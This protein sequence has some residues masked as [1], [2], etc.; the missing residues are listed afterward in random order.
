MRHDVTV[1]ATKIRKLFSSSAA[2]IKFQAVLLIFWL[3]Y[4]LKSL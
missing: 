3:T 4:C 2:E 1:T